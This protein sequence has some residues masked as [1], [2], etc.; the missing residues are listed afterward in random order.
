[1]EKK[2]QAEVLT[3]TLIFELIIGV[4][5]ASILMYAV[6]NINN[7]SSF[8]QEYIKQD[9]FFIKEMVRSLPGD[10]NMTYYTG[11]WCLADNEQFTKSSN[12]WVQIIK[13]GDEIT[14]K[15][16]EKR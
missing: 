5:I 6:L 1:M 16:A 14:I 3:T 9:L 12:C 4:I 8:N 10:L 2:G 13:T 11:N 15:K 7:A